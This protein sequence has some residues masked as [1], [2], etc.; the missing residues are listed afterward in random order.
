VLDDLGLVPAVDWLLS[1]LAGRTGI[2]TALEEHGER[3]RLSPEQ[4]LVVFRVAQEALHNIERHAAA[5]RVVVRLAYYP[6][7]LF[8]E[9]VDDGCGFDPAHVRDGSLGLAGMQERASLIGA[10]LDVSSRPGA[11]SVKLDLP[12][13]SEPLA[14]EMAM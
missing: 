6:D 2:R 3:L 9:V 8:L 7:R 1:D 4:E 11:T 10:A 12:L 5:S 13:T 14:A